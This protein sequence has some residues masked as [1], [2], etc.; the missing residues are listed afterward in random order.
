MNDTKF[1]AEYVTRASTLVQ[2]RKDDEDA[3]RASL[4]ETY[5]RDDRLSGQLL[6]LDM[7]LRKE[8]DDLRKEYGIE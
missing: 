7:Q 6:Q 5:G 1:P 8:L 4:G 3:L 2:K